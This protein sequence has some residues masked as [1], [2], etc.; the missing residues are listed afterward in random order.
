MVSVTHVM[1]PVRPALAHKDWIA[2]HVSKVQIF[3]VFGYAGNL[4]RPSSYQTLH[5]S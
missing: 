1:H 4:R 2:L 5:L 3:A